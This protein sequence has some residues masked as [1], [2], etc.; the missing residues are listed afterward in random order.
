MGAC[1]LASKATLRSGAGLAVAHIPSHGNRIL[2][3]SVPEVMTD[4]DK[5]EEFITELPDISMFNSIGIGPGIGTDAKTAEV[6]SELLDNTNV[7]VI[8]DADALN[9]ISMYNL[10]DKLHGNCVLTPHPKEF[11]RLFG[12]TEN[13]PMAIDL[14]REKSIS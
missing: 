10:Q 3:S 12:S 11:D 14:Q 8:I 6:V 4:C 1:I 7:P 13:T 9:C 5:N 2:Q